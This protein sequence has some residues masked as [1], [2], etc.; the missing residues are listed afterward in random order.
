MKNK[1]ALLAVSALK[2]NRQHVQLVFV[3]V[4]LAM[5]VIGTGAPSAEGGVG[6]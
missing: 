6:K 3:L 2:I 1:F 5:L 4:S